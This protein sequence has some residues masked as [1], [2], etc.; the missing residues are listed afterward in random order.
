MPAFSFSIL[1]NGQLTSR[2]IEA[3]DLAAARGVARAGGGRILSET[4]PRGAGR[5][6]RPQR[7]PAFPLWLFCRELSALLDAGMTSAEALNALVSKADA[8]PAREALER[9]E[10]RL[11]EGRRLSAAMAEEAA[12]FPELLVAV[13]GA[14]EETGQLAGALRR[15][16]D[17][18]QHVDQLRKQLSGALLYPAI[19]LSVGLLVVVFMLFFVIPGF[20]SLLASAQGALPFTSRMMIAWARLLSAYRLEVIGGLVGVFAVFAWSVGSRAGRAR[21]FAAILRIPALRRIHR[22]FELNRFYSAFG[23]VLQGGMPIPRALQLAGSLLGSHRRAALAQVG[24]ALSAGGTLSDALSAH[25][26]TTPVAE[27]LLRVG[28]HTGELG[29]ICDHIVRFHDESLARVHELATKV[30]GPVVM[31]VVGVMVGGLMVLLYMP[32]FDLAGGLGA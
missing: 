23:L 12:L 9:L 21:W 27:R 10:A 28:E 24:E 11:Q 1:E 4:Q 5:S 14:S 19:V 2:T 8:G 16:L 31:L 30:L 18:Q 32:I 3:A 20:A 17:Y 7:K 13:V 26:M 29:A 15:F 22:L 25:D 6:W